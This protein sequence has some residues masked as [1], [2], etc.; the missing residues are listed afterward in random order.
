MPSFPIIAIVGPT[1]I[2]K[3]RV[4]ISVAKAL[5]A[6]VVSVDSLQ[7]YRH[8]G[9][10]TAKPTPEE[11]D[12]VPHHLIDYLDPDEEPVDVLTLAIAKIQQIHEAGKIPLIV[13]GSISLTKPLLLQPLIQQNQLS[14]IILHSK[15]CRLTPRLDARVDD[16][17]DRGLFEEVRLLRALE[18]KASTT[19]GCDRG[20]WKAIGYNELRSVL[21]CDK[22]DP[23][24][25]NGVNRM[26]ERTVRYAQ[27]QMKVIWSE[28]IP[29]IQERKLSFAVFTVEDFTTFENRVV[30][31][32]IL[33]AF[34]W[35]YG[36]SR[37]CFQ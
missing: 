28:L 27:E 22:T 37:T 8:G 18:E 10:I 26:K 11:M 31:P 14:V 32:A 20:V 36:N 12:G 35:I 1:G 6:E 29:A 13:G 24:W 3:T 5:N 34:E 16:M 2:G 21:E 15:L 9:I 25:T 17:I 19:P 7:V 23:K 4:G 33:Q 30:Q